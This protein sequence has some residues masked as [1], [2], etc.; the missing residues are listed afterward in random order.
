MND[1]FGGL[2]AGVRKAAVLSEDGMYRYRLE[3]VWDAE[4]PPVCWV[5]LNPSK[6]DAEQDDPT[7]TRCVGFARSWGWGGIVV[8]NLFA[9][10]ATDP[11]DLLR[12]LKAGKDVIGPEND[13]HIIDAAAGQFTVAAWGANAPASRAARVVELLGPNALSLDCLGF[14]KKGLPLHPLMVRADKALVPFPAR[15]DA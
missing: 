5:M 12:A 2:T 13:Q 9:F 8:C 14:T 4:V 6:A 15:A 1:L 7:I 10:R 3:R 11:K